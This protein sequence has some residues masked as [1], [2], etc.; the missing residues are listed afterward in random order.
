MAD[1]FLSIALV[2][3]GF[4]ELQQGFYPGVYTGLVTTGYVLRLIAYGVLLVGIYG[5]QRSDLRALRAANAAL[6][7]MRVSEGERAALEERTRLA[8]EIH[9]G[10]AQQ[11][12]FAKL[13]FD[14]LAAQ[15][16]DG[17]RAT[18]RRGGTGAGRGTR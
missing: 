12:W 11:L 9:D 1:G 7:R 3:A 18:L 17:R 5:E 16:P 8:R 6:D 2:I 13:K 15:L 14:R 4:A 10:L